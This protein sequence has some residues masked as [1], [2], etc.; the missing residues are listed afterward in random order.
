MK[1]L[2]NLLL[3]YQ[4]NYLILTK[5]NKE[6][7]ES[8]RWFFNADN[9]LL[10]YGNAF[11]FFNNIDELGN[12]HLDASQICN[13]IDCEIDNL[14]GSNIK[15]TFIDLIRDNIN[16]PKLKLEKMVKDKISE[17]ED[18]ILDAIDE[19]KENKESE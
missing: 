14:Y 17:Y 3:K 8:C 10:H 16:K 5:I 6:M 13:K 4:D 18:E 2:L 19:L 9:D 1:K 12:K 7:K 15:D 11:M